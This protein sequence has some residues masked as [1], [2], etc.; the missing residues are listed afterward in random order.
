MDNGAELNGVLLKLT[1][2][3]MG[4]VKDRRTVASLKKFKERTGTTIYLCRC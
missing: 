2:A 4:S 3:A 1:N